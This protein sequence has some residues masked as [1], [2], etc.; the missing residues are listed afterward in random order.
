VEKGEIGSKRMVR[1][2][3]RILRRPGRKK[4]VV[5]FWG[6]RTG[7]EGGGKDAQGKCLRRLLKNHFL[8]GTEGD[9]RGDY[10]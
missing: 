6:W 5:S 2:E 4:L 10:L 9:E 7:I 1:G 8:S 3:N